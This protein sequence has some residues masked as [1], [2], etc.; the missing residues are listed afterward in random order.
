MVICS[1]ARAPA[2]TRHTLLHRPLSC[3]LHRTTWQALGHVPPLFVRDAFCE[4][5][6]LSKWGAA[7][8]QL[9]TAL[10]RLPDVLQQLGGLHLVGFETW[11]VPGL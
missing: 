4:E 7:L 6:D 8:A 10:V 1:F 3:V 5:S 2:Q 11:W 9:H